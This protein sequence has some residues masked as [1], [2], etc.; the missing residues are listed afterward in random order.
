MAVRDELKALAKLAQM[1]HSAR[2]LDEELKRIPAHL[3]EL[4]GSVQTLE[5]LLAQERSQ[6][7]EAETLKVDRAAE[8][9]ARVE[10]LQRARRNAAQAT[11]MKES[12]AGEREVEVNRRAIKEREEDLKRIGEA[13]EAKTASLAER[14][15]DFQEAQQMLHAEEET[16]K[17]KVD[18]LEAERNKLLAGRDEIVGVIRQYPVSEFGQSSLVKTVRALPG[19]A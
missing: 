12:Q 19:P 10:G 9:K 11:N 17:T 3:E 7:T 1:D 4:R 16:S 2:D 6:L 14:E 8:L 13:I 18:E 15:K 5:A